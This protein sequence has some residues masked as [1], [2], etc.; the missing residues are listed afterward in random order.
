MDVKLTVSKYKFKHY[1]MLGTEL[2]RKDGVPQDPCSG[3][4]GGP[5]MYK[6]EESRQWVI[7]GQFDP[8]YWC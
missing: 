4:S 8:V 5:L 6:E 1:K 3:D 2:K 7:I